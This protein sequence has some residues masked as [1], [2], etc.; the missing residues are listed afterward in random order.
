MKQR[1]SF[2]VLMIFA[3]SFGLQ[4]QKSSYRHHE[5]GL[6]L[7]QSYGFMYGAPMNF[8]TLYKVGPSENAVWRFQLGTLQFGH[9][10]YEPS[11]QL[12][13]WVGLGGLIG[14]EWRKDISDQLRL[15]HG[16]MV[17]LDMSLSRTRTDSPPTENG[18]VYLTPGLS[19]VIGVMYHFNGPFYMAAEIHP[20]INTQFTYSN[21]ALSPNRYWS[22]GLS[23][24]N[25]LLTVAYE[26]QTYK[27]GK[28]KKARGVVTTPE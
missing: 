15:Y 4:A 24:Q 6:Q 16:P 2:F 18:Y 19:Y 23:G 13:S 26:F 22:G 9:N 5:I 1:L 25:A 11:Q 3:L 10:Y 28:S 14:R 17:G 27:K 21:D 12:S 8:K 7:D 20:G